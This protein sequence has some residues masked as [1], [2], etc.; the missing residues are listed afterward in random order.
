M[1]ENTYKPRH[2]RLQNSFDSAPL[3]KRWLITLGVIGLIILLFVDADKHGPLHRLYTRPPVIAEHVLANGETLVVHGVLRNGVDSMKLRGETVGDDFQFGMTLVISCKNPQTGLSSDWTW[4]S[5][6]ELE[7]RYGSVVRGYIADLIYRTADGEI[8]NRSSDLTNLKNCTEVYY[9]IHFPEVET[10][11]PCD[12]LAIGTDDEVWARVESPF[13]PPE[14]IQGFYE[15]SHDLVAES[16][17][18]KV[19]LSRIVSHWDATQRRPYYGNINHPAFLFEH[20]GRFLEKEHVLQ[21]DGKFSDALGNPIGSFVELNKQPLWKYSMKV[22]RMDYPAT[23]QTKELISIGRIN[24]PSESSELVIADAPTLKIQMALYLPV[25]KHEKI[26]QTLNQGDESLCSFGKNHSFAWQRLFRSSATGGASG[27]NAIQRSHTEADFDIRPT[28]NV[29]HLDL[30]THTNQPA[31]LKVDTKLPLVILE[32]AEP[33]NDRLINL[34]AFD[35]LNRALQVNTVP[36]GLEELP[37]F[38]VE[39]ESDTKQIDLFYSIEPIV[40]VEFY[41][42][43]PLKEVV[44]LESGATWLRMSGT[45]DG[46]KVD[47]Q[48]E[49][50]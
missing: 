12:F 32:L 6:F 45:K 24:E 39:S 2:T 4:F 21:L 17:S 40:P 35:Q 46:W 16:G 8:E 3:V 29:L 15:H 1:S 5:H 26:V 33:L 27:H 22:A 30:T 47:Q 28:N 18:W 23:K 19:E 31:R 10:V 48:H 36:S 41:M 9:V 42:V 13:P 44:L 25:G 49:P 34:F 14:P 7:D 50:K 37:M 20:E 43:P 38:V 11:K